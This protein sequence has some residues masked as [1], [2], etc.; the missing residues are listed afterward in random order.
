[1]CYSVR[2]T[3]L[4]QNPFHKV[5]ESLTK[6][7]FFICYS[8]S[9]LKF[10]KSPHNVGSNCYEF[11]WFITILYASLCCF[12]FLHF[13]PLQPPLSKGYISSSPVKKLTRHLIFT[14]RLHSLS[15]LYC[16]SSSPKATLL[17]FLVAFPSSYFLSFVVML[18]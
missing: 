5:N 8:T 10:G 7:F 15:L 16:H 17:I 9:K 18:S 11:L 2:L 1:M 12:W 14:F 6:S 4:W 13:Y 3:S